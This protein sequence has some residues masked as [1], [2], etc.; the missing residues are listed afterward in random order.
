MGKPPF[1]D[2]SRRP[3]PSN[4]RTPTG[5]H[6]KQIA[7][8]LSDVVWTI[9]L[10]G[11]F[12]YVSPS[13]ERLRGYRPEEIVGSLFEEAL[14]PD[15]GQEIR[16]I[17]PEVLALFRNSRTAQVRHFVTQPCRDGST[18]PSEILTNGV[19]DDQGNLV[20]V[21]G[22]TRDISEQYRLEQELRAAK[23]EAERALAEVRTLA[24][25]LP[26]CSACK[27]IRDDTGFWE[28]VEDYISSH[29]G[30]RF[31]HGMCPECMT[32]FYPECTSPSG[33]CM[34]AD[35]TRPASPQAPPSP[36]AE[37]PPAS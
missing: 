30:A 20:A 27:K 1:P 14:M 18:V 22:V 9:D 24:G 2:G 15:E 13:V 5:D 35:A 19:Y 16:R 10:D 23:E 17:F 12:T 6:F 26:I 3:E 33:C 37:R 7:D 8:H 4:A 34:N 36:L 31:S 32:R 21:L 29:T 25:L 11:R 28:R